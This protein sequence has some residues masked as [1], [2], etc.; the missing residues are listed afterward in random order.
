MRRVLGS[1]L[2]SR[3]TAAAQANPL[4]ARL[5]QTLDEI[6]EAGTF[7][8]ERVITSA[9]DPEVRVAGSDSDV[10]TMCSNNY[11]GLS[12]HPRLVEAA[13]KT[14]DTHGVGMSSVRFICGTQDIHKDLERAISTF[15]GCDD[16]ILFP[17]CFDVRLPS[18]CAPLDAARIARR[19]QTPAAHLPPAWTPPRRTRAC[20]RRFL[21]RR[22]P[23]SLMRSTTR[24][25]STA[26]GCARR[27]GTA[28]PT[29]TWTTSRRSSRPRRSSHRGP[30]PRPR[31]TPLTRVTPGVGVAGQAHAADR[32][33][34]RLLDGRR[35]RAARQDLRARRAVQRAGEPTPTSTGER[36]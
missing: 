15:H 34:R 14:L 25:L 21:G 22:T 28:T 19:V 36:G 11:L 8:E 26:S 35:R 6:R 2:R 30:I 20:S 5:A 10:I 31:A 27:S 23:S 12:N 7:K 13:K 29:A 24:R 4:T 32:D 3:S 18:L 9:M 1:S 16:T 17:S 33:G